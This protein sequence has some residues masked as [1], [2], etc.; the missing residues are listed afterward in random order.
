MSCVIVVCISLL[1]LPSPCIVSDCDCTY[2]RISGGRGTA[3]RPDE[4]R[5]CHSRRIHQHLP[6]SVCGACV[7]VC[8]RVCI[9]LCADSVCGDTPFRCIRREKGNVTRSSATGS[10]SPFSER[11]MSVDPRDHCLSLSVRLFDGRALT[12]AR[13]IRCLLGKQIRVAKEWPDQHVMQKKRERKRPKHRQSEDQ[14]SVGIQSGDGIR[15]WYLF[16][17]HIRMSAKQRV[18]SPT[19]TERLSS[20]C[21]NP[22]SMHEG[23]RVSCVC[24][25]NCFCI[26]VSPHPFFPMISM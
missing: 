18:S 10:Q 26:T 3:R 23:R 19:P 25:S 2:P 20:V 1:A 9:S 21:E 11:D 8:L 17:M 6:L 16:S 22:L 4:W 12:H 24:E 13:E 14:S 7:C 5:A 15:K